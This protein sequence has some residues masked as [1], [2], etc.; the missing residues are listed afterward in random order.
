M[1]SDHLQIYFQIPAMVIFVYLK[2]SLSSAPT[3][4]KNKCQMTEGMTIPL[5]LM[6][7]VLLVTFACFLSNKIGPCILSDIEKNI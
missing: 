6:S 7:C 2:V 5:A 4:E 1:F 3:D